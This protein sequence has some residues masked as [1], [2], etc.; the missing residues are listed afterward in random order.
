MY[1]TGI[2]TK[3]RD[4]LCVSAYDILNVDFITDTY[5][6][7]LHLS[8]L[9]RDII[10]K[11]AVNFDRILLSLPYYREHYQHNAEHDETTQYYFR[12]HT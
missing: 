2:S 7:S 5:S 10:T 8:P 12:R 3:C 11:S 4:T 6:V 9:I 1:K